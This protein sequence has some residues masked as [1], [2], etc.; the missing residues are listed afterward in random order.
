MDFNLKN[1]CDFLVDLKTM[2]TVQNPFGFAASCCA[3][4]RIEKFFS[5]LICCYFVDK[6]DDF[7]FVYQPC[8]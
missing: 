3:K 5:A 6:N 8:G 7:L 2:V 1:L 4:Q